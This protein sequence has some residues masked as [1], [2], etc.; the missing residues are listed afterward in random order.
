M[1]DDPGISTNTVDGCAVPTQRAVGQAHPKRVT[2]KYLNSAFTAETWLFL[3]HGSGNVLAR[4][5]LIH[6]ALCLNADNAFPRN[7]G[8]RLSII[9]RTSA[10]ALKRLSALSEGSASTSP[11]T[12]EGSGAANQVAQALSRTRTAR[13]LMTGP[14]DDNS[15]DRTAG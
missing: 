11:T 7:Y 13:A 8:D 15:H 14:Q 6:N 12:S 9:G 10:A 3:H 5:D 4:E 1:F 2:T